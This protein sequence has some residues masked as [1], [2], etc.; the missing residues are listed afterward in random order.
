MWKGIGGWREAK[1]MHKLTGVCRCQVPACMV[2]A[3]VDPLVDPRYYQAQK[4]NSPLL[5]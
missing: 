4:V 2:K 1:R 5:H 3:A